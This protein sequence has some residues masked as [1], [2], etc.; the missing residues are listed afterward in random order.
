MMFFGVEI[1]R[2]PGTML[3]FAGGGGHPGLF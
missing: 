2:A 3:E 1:V